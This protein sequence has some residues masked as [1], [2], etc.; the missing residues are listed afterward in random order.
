M[1]IPYKLV[2]VIQVELVQGTRFR[3]KK[4]VDAKRALLL[5]DETGERMTI[6]TGGRLRI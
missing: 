1:A 6:A 5:R 3:L 2:F 4:N